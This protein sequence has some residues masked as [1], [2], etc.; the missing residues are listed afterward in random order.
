MSDEFPAAWKIFIT[1]ISFHEINQFSSNDTFSQMK[2]IYHCC[3][4][5]WLFLIKMINYIRVK[6]I[7][8]VVIFITLKDFHYGDNLYDFILLI[9]LCS[10][11]YSYSQSWKI[12][13]SD[14]FSLYCKQICIVLHFVN[15]HWFASQWWFSSQY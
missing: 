6:I 12:H 8:T 11:V 3:E 4:S 5:F 13:Q 9:R 2:L 14:I 15:I 1:L 10:I 7:I